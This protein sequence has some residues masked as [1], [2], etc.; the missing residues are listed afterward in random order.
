MVKEIEVV[1]VK[2]SDEAFNDQDENI[3]NKNHIFTVYR[4][5]DKQLIS[6]V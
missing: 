2:V 5:T 1:G 4:D 6:F 3:W